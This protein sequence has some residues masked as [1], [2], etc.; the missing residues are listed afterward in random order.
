MVVIDYFCSYLGPMLL[1]VRGR[2]EMLGIAG[3][4]GSS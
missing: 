1:V 3:R 4:P 2:A